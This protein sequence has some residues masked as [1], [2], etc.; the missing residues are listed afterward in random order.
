MSR[1][2]IKAKLQSL[3]EDELRKK[4]VIPLL[5]CSGFQYVEDWCGPGE[6]GKDVLYAKKDPLLES[7]F[8]GAVLIKNKNDIRKG[9]KTDIRIIKNQVEEA[10]LT[11]IPDP[12]DPFRKTII[13]EL[14]IVTSFNIEPEAREYIGVVFKESHLFIRF[15]PGDK[16]ESK[17][18]D[19]I[20][21]SDYVFD[22]DNFEEFCEKQMESV[23]ARER[24]VISKPVFVSE[25]SEGRNIEPK[26]AK[27]NQIIQS[28]EYSRNQ[29]LILDFFK[30]EE[31]KSYFLNKLPDSFEDLAEI[32]FILEELVKD[33]RP[34]K[35]IA[36]L[37]KSIG[38]RN[39]E[40]IINFINKHYEEPGR[41][42]E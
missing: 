14:Y 31:L 30:D 18:N 32:E 15:M 9:S 38:E 4:V 12:L 35:L 5:R 2:I 8:W 19:V 28:G 7:Y 20:G 23:F 1:M 39:I 26:L 42:F 29:D 11:Q 34:F 40:F 25:I 10:I 22:L 16:L 21:R 13:R 33:E 37:R 3:S 27:I 41:S 17:I 36:I 24:E 6:K